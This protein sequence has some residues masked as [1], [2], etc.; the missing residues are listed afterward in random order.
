M[1][2]TPR[3]ILDEV[4]RRIHM[5]P[6]VIRRDEQLRAKPRHGGLYRGAENSCVTK[7]I[8]VVRA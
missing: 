8:T 2:G 1:I 4:V 6:S 7:S 5:G 3:P